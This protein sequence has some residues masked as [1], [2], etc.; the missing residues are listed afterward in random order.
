MT[1]KP[2]EGSFSSWTALPSAPWLAVM[3]AKSFA[4]PTEPR[5][6]LVII[7]MILLLMFKL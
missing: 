6:A 5:I 3:F 1:K 7:L 2:L 4:G